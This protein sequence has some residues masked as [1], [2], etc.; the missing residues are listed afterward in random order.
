MEEEAVPELKAGEF[1][2]RNAYLSMDPAMVGRMRDEDNYADAVVPGETMHA[3]GV[4]QVVRSRCAALKVGEVVLGR[5]DMQEYAVCNDAN[6][7]TRINAGIAQPSWFLSAVGI[8][9]ATAY[10]SLFDIA[11]PRRGETILI[12]AGASSVGSLVAQLAKRVG[13]RTVAIVSTDDKAERTR[14]KF[15]YD[16]AISYRG[17][18]IQTLS[19]DIAAA[20]P[21]GV[22]IYYDNTSG[23]ISEAVLDHYN[24]F[25]RIVV[26]GRLGLSHLTDTKG[27][28][29]RRDNNVL[30]T[31][32]ITKQGFVL[33]DY[34]A[35]MPAAVLQLAKWA[36]RG[37][38]QVQED[39][40]HGI[41]QIPD[42]FLRMLDGRNQGK[43]LVK[44][45]DIDRKLDPAPR[46]LGRA[47]TSEH[48][49]TGLLARVIGTGRAAG[50]K[51]ART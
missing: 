10:F 2:V 51:R 8:T 47:L 18:D 16:A 41:D 35:R 28:V 12:S 15:G 38:L 13:C 33:L 4:G 27:D 5:L 25:A 45:A 17:K 23:D 44:L 30:L 14:A 37:D 34:R 43:Q 39:V 24:E 6:E 32:R 48:F 22:D 36:R 11:K 20:C 46:W 21:S 50:A 29:G 7:V 40:A 19:K 31:K 3:Y 9:G 49:P 42:A 26:V 1:L